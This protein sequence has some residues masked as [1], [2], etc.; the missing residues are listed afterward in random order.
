VAIEEDLRKTAFCLNSRRW[1]FK[2]LPTIPR[3]CPYLG[4]Q[5]NRDCVYEGC[6]YYEVRE[7]RGQ[8]RRDYL[9][10]LSMLRIGD[11]WKAAVRKE[12]PHARA[13]PS[14]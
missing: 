2:F 4:D 3:S 14:P 1:L 10:F 13:K 5:G 11:P 7:P 9:V 6:G 12:A 8:A